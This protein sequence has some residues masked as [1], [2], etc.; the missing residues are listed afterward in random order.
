MFECITGRVPFTGATAAEIAAKHVRERPP[1]LRALNPGITPSAEFVINKAMAR[2]IGRRYRSADEMLVDLEKLADGIELDRTGVLG[3]PTEEATLPMT[4]TP[5][6]VPPPAQAPPRPP[7]TPAGGSVLGP[8]GR[9]PERTPGN[10]AAV[11]TV[12]VIV[13]ILALV[14]VGLLI[15]QAVAPP[16]G[17][18]QVAVP[19]VKGMALPEAKAALEQAGLKLGKISYVEDPGAPEGTVVQ[20]TPEIGLSAAPQTAVDLVISRGKQTVTVPDVTQRSVA[21]ATERLEKEGLHIGSL[22]KIFHETI[23]AGLVVK[24]AIA[25][26]TRV[27][28]GTTIDLT[29]SKGPEATVTKPDTT[30]PPGDNEQPV[31]EDPVVE[32]RADENY[33]GSNANERRVIVKVSAMGTDMGQRIQIVKSDDTGRERTVVSATMDPGA[34]REWPVQITG[35]AIIEVLHNDRSVFRA[36]YS[37]TGGGQ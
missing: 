22:D 19:A 2:E 17:N 13:A 37:V 30:T 16:A 31:A 3:L 6:M 25:A 24:Q 4:P 36:P 15:K 12:A 18:T 28:G 7:V 11:T 9:Q 10:V 34:S 8:S 21:E 5:A 26:G 27:E 35:N 14:G 1:A 20:Q 33:T 29:V 23:P 32:I